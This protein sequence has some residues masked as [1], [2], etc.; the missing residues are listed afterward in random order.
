MDNF[1]KAVTVIVTVILITVGLTLVFVPSA[2]RKYE[3]YHCLIANGSPIYSDET[4][5]KK[6]R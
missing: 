2:S 1:E 6:E 5:Y 3:G 4:C